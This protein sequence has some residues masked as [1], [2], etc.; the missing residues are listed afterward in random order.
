MSPE[1]LNKK[2]FFI[3]DHSKRNERGYTAMVKHYANEKGVGCLFKFQ[4][5][6]DYIVQEIKAAMTTKVSRLDIKNDKVRNRA[7]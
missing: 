6:I 1:I 7:G 3:S 2:T 4:D 5:D